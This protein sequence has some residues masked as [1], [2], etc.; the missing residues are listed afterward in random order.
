[1]GYCSYTDLVTRI[2]STNLLKICEVT[3]ATLASPIVADAIAAADRKIDMYLDQR[4]SVPFTDG[5]VPDTAKQ[6]SIDFTHW[7]LRNDRS[8]RSDELDAKYLAWEALLE[9]IS[10]REKNFP[11]AVEIDPVASAT[12]VTGNDAVFTRTTMEG[13]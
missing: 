7:N 11:G 4:Y 1:M 9:A 10:K 6:I 8:K 2:G 13:L 3:T 5:S 12:E